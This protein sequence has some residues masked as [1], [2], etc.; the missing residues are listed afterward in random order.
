LVRSPVD[1]RKIDGDTFDIVPAARGVRRYIR[2]VD[3]GHGT[4][5]SLLDRF[6][7]ALVSNRVMLVVVIAHRRGVGFGGDL[8]YALGVSSE[9]AVYPREMLEASIAIA[10][11]GET[12]A[13]VSYFKSIRALSGRI[14]PWI[15]AK[16]H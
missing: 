6:P 2:T 13:L 12:D 8:G 3:R 11:A 10:M 7:D 4:L 1:L 5:A 9:V 14:E 16:K 15:T